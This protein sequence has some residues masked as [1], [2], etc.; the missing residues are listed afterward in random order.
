MFDFVRFEDR[1][2]GLDVGVRTQQLMPEVVLYGRETMMTSAS[3]ASGHRRPSSAG[4][5]QPSSGP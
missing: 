1:H 5:D 2:A 3:A 4:R